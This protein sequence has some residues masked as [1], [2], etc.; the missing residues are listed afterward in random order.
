MKSITQVVENLLKPYIDGK[1]QNIY[2]VMGK[3]GAKALLPMS[4]ADIKARHSAGTW[5]GNA[6]TING[7]TYTINIDSDGFITDIVVTGTASADAT[8]TVYGYSYTSDYAK[9]FDVPVIASTDFVGSD[10]TAR[11]I[12]WGSN[13][14]YIDGTELQIAAGTIYGF[15]LRVVNGYEI[16]EGGITFKPMLRFAS[17]T[18][19]TYQPYVKTNKELTAE[20]GALTN[21]FTK[22]ST[23]NGAVNE[24]DHTGVTDTSGTVKFTV[25]EDKSIRTLN[26]FMGRG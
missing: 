10:S 21:A 14:G 2:K 22:Q 5:N 24:L 15:G 7:I 20:N 6:Y 4:L 26:K 9:V 25:N 17:D 8:L 23:V 11:G 1:D 16:P 13:S 18:D 19:A 3:M 12:I